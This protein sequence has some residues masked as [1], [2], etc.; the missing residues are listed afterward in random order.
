MF[1]VPL[2]LT[3]ISAGNLFYEAT[4]RGYGG[5]QETGTAKKLIK[6]LKKGKGI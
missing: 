3:L 4:G 1:K 2:F 5:Y 6:T